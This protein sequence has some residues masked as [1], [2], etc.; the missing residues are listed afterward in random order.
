VEHLNCRYLTTLDL[1]VAN[2][3][4]DKP[5]IWDPALEL[6]AERGALHERRVQ[7]FRDDA[8]ATRSRGLQPA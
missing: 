7:T 6:L 8:V 1:K 4:P 2:G 5:N 3:D